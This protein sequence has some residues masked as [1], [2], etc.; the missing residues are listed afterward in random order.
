MKIPID[1][2]HRRLVK[3]FGASYTKD[4]KDVP[5]YRSFE[6]GLLF[7][8][9]DFDE[10][11]RKLKKGEKVAIVSGLNPSCALH[12]GHKG[13]FD[14]NIFF[15]KKYGIDVFIPLSDDESYLAGKIPDQKTGLKN[16]QHLVKQLLALGFDPKKTKFVIDQIYTEIYNLAIKFSKLVTRST[17][18]ATYGHSDEVNIGLQ[19]YPCV[20]AAHI[21]MPLYLGYKHVLVP[22][23]ID[24][25]MHLR[26][27][28]DIAGKLNLPKPAVLHSAFMPGVDGEKMSKSRPD[29]AIF[30]DDDLKSVKKKV[31]R[32]FSG[33]R[34]SL[35]EHRKYGG[36]PE[37]DVALKYLTAYFLSQKDADKLEAEY[38]KGK[39]LSSE[40]KEMLYKELEKFLT[41]YKKRFAKI[42]DKDANSVIIKNKDFHLV[43]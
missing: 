2:E 8:H 13:V 4:L 18:K 35:E 33:G 29:T 24:E 19:F 28:R 26:I 22:I 21:L 6:S 38:K 39:V 1:D 43:V 9:R 36:I 10:F 15:Q 41:D 27:S 20:Q 17:I 30:L 7:S 3:D 14:T 40:L 23:S 25:D 12:I 32:A 5:E 31:M 11:F 16:A 34:G 42:S 37:N